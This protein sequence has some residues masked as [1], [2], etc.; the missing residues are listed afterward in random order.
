MTKTLLKFAFLFIVLVLTQ[1]VVFNHLVLLGVAVPFVFIYG[2]IRL[3][4]NLNINWVMTIAFLLG[5]AVDIFSDTND[6][7]ALACT[8]F[9]VLRLPVL[10][11]YFP[12]VQDLTDPEPSMRSLGPAVY[13]K[14]LVSMSLLYSMLFFIIESMTFFNITRLLMSIIGSAALTFVFILAIEIIRQ[15]EK[16]L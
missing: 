2:I 13:M 10:R 6:I 8:F 3:P 12:R 15:R 4:V 7:N 14:Y 5:T 11:L 1:V 9:S 16:R